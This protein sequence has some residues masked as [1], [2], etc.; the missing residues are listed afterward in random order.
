MDS[1]SDDGAGG[2]AEKRHDIQ[3]FV[4]SFGGTNDPIGNDE[5]T[6]IDKS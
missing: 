5:V 2:K 6:I 1:R 4:F 3:L